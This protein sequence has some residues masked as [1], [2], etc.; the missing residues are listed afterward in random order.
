LSIKDQPA[1]EQPREKARDKG[2]SALTDSELLAI[3]LRVGTKGKTVLEL[4]REMIQ[5]TGGLNE[6]AAKSFG[7]FQKEFSGIGSDKAITIAAV[8]EIAKRVQ[9]TGK[10]YLSDKITSPDLIA[11][12]FIRYLKNEP[13]EK[14]M[15]AFISTGGKI[16]K[17][18]EVFQGTIDYS[19]VDVREIIKRT[20]DHNAKSIIICHNHPSGSTDISPE[21]RRITKR[22]KEAC[23]IFDIKLLDHIVVAGTKFVSFSHLGMLNLD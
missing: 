17:I 3:I 15:I 9:T 4:A 5:K 23:N 14:F 1:D 6:L 11:E 19:I 12:H 8:F 2:I 21:D 16:I 10:E 18:E 7:F 22:I 13:I 20:L